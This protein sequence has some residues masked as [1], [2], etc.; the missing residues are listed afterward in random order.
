MSTPF[1]YPADRALTSFTNM[2]PF[3]AFSLCTK[4]KPGS[5]LNSVQ[6]NKIKKCATLKNTKFILFGSN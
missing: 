1:C 4:L 6:K 2:D 3:F 5:R